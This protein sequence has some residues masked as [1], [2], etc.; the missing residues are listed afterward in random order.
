MPLRIE[1]F[2]NDVG[3][4]AIYKALSHP[5]MVPAAHA[6]LAKLAALESLAVYDPDGIAAVLDVFYPL[7]LANVSGYF[8]QNV[9]HLNGR[10][11]HLPARPVTEIVQAAPP[12][13]FVATFETERKL[14]PIRHLLLK[15]AEIFSLESL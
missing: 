9:E 15:G 6:L 4:S 13:V 5:L 10:F 2:R 14:M 1:T 8:V 7:T 11:H 3:G 12:A